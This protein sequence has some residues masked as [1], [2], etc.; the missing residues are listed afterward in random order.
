MAR[1]SEEK[2]CV[3]SLV[4]ELYSDRYRVGSMVLLLYF[5]RKILHY[6]RQFPALLSFPRF[7]H[8]A[9]SVS[10]VHTMSAQLAILVILHIPV[11]L[12]IPT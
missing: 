11:I 1:N 9:I 6:G 10:L 4:V 8:L 5:S 12:L 2:R 7:A 3:Y